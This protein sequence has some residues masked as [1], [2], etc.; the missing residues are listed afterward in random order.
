MD[1]GQL[2]RFVDQS[3]YSQPTVEKSGREANCGNFSVTGFPKE[4]FA[5]V[6]DASKMPIRVVGWIG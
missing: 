4:D 2:A 6:R 1:I 5:P 3:P